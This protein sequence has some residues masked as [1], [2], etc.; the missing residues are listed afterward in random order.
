MILKVTIIGSDGSYPA[1]GGACSG[2][3]LRSAEATV[4]VDMGTGTLARLQQVMA[5]QDLDA[6]I[7]SHRHADHCSDLADLLVLYRCADRKAQHIPVYAA[8]GV[9]EQVFGDSDVEPNFTWT[10]LEDGDDLE[11]GNLNFKFARVDHGPVT[12]AMRV[13]CGK[14]TFAYTADTGPDWSMTELGHR[15]DVAFVEAAFR[16][17]EEG[18]P[19]LHLSPRQ[20]AAMAKEA[21]VDRLVLTHLRPDHDRAL[22]HA[23]AVAAFGREVVLAENGD[24]FDV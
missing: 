1:P 18:A 4:M 3:L 13:D 10:E 5:P 7:L 20:A 6:V 9:R 12:F 23:Q 19:S 2:Y 21:G 24:T 16:E 8:P 17:D 22:I 14:R 11:I 15:I